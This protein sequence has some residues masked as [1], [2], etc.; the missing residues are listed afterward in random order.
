MASARHVA[1]AFFSSGPKYILGDSPTLTMVR[2]SSPSLSHKLFAISK[3][4]AS[5]IRHEVL[6]LGFHSG[7]YRNQNTKYARYKQKE[8]RGM[9]PSARAHCQ[10]AAVVSSRLKPS[11]ASVF[12]PTFKLV[13]ALL[14]SFL[15]S[16]WMWSLM[17]SKGFFCG[18]PTINRAICF[19]CRMYLL[20]CRSP[21]RQLG[22]EH[23]APWCSATL[24]KLPSPN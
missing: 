3:A 4:G 12:H 14:S 22:T 18:H 15:G 10:P 8:K 23:A 17:H 9:T 2:F 7:I 1:C 19:P 16:R 6:A 20:E 24:P 21:G 11:C 13:T 5:L